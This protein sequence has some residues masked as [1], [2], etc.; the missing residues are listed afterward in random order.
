VVAE[1]AVGNQIKVEMLAREDLAPAENKQRDDGQGVE[2]VMMSWLASLGRGALDDQ[3]LDSAGS[4]GA[5]Y[6]EGLS[7]VQI[8]MTGAPMA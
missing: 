7:E 4:A 6:W 1:E 5:V 2:E 8:Q 3:E